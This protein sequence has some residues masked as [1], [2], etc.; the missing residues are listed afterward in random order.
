MPVRAQC[1]LK[2]PC[3]SSNNAPCGRME[4]LPQTVLVPAIAGKREANARVHLARAFG[5]G[6][7]PYHLRHTAAHHTLSRA[8]LSFTLLLI[9]VRDSACLASNFDRASATTEMFAIDHE[10]SP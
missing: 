5:G 7:Q 2:R 1:S 4:G 3:A 6:P 9:G 10:R 8:L